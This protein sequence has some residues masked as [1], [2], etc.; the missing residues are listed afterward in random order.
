MRAAEAAA[1]SVGTAKPTPSLPPDSERIESLMP[2]TLP[3]RSASAPPELPGLIGASV[4]R[5]S[6]T[7]PPWVGRLRLTALTKAEAG[8][9]Q[10]DD[11]QY[12]GDQARAAAPGRAVATAGR[13]AA[14]GRTGP[15]GLWD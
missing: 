7:E 6:K 15:G 4:C 12:G 10:Q 5:T 11:G 8:A 14:P 2:M 13:R 3:S 1:M 9:E